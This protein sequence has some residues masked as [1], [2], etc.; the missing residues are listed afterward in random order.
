M[1]PETE[2]LKLH[3]GHKVIN[4]LTER[5]AK[6]YSCKIAFSNLVKLSLCLQKY[7]PKNYFTALDHMHKCIKIAGYNFFVE[8][9][10]DKK[11]VEGG[12]W[13]GEERLKNLTDILEQIEYDK[14]RENYFQPIAKDLAKL[15]GVGYEV[16]LAKMLKEFFAPMCEIINCNL[17]ILSEQEGVDR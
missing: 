3:I 7:L 1:Y 17:S 8:T 5:M 12:I 4:F 6:F 11:V 16:I 14:L 15:I 9:D 13:R 10:E 2:E